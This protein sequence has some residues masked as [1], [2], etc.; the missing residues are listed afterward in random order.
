MDQPNVTITQR[1]GYQFENGFAPGITT[2]RTDEPP[3]LGTGTGPSPVDLLAAA[4]GNCLT[5][6]LQFACQ[7]YKDDPAPLRAAVQATTGRNE[8]NRM[9]VLGLAV[10]LHLGKPAAELPHLAR[11]LETFED[12]CTV[13][14]SIVAAV[15]VTLRVIDSTG[16]VLKG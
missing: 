4:V 7:K 14:Q 10:D 5:A 6:S 2:L 9:R 15:P 1:Q 13:T 3:P 11:V 16:A 8:R 12:F